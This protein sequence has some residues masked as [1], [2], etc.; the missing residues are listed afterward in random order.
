[1]SIWSEISS[2]LSTKVFCCYDDKPNDKAGED[3]DGNNIHEDYNVD[4]EEATAGSNKGDCCRV[5]GDTG[6]DAR[7]TDPPPQTGLVLRIEAQLSQPSLG[8]R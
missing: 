5:S 4:C 8:S 7:T 1:M 6:L 3:E 2:P